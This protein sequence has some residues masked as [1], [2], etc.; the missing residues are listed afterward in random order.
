DRIR[1][2]LVAVFSAEADRRPSAGLVVD[3]VDGARAIARQAVDV[4]LELAARSHLEQEMTLEADGFERIG[5]KAR[6][7][8][9]G[10][11]LRT[12]AAVLL[13]VAALLD[14]LERAADLRARAVETCAVEL[15]CLFDSRSPAGVALAEHPFHGS[16]HLLAHERLDRLERFA[17][18]VDVAITIAPRTLLERR[19]AR[20]AERLE[21]G[22]RRSMG[23]FVRPLQCKRVHGFGDAPDVLRTDRGLRNG[24]RGQ[25]RS[26][27]ATKRYATH[28]VIAGRPAIFSAASR[29]PAPTST[30][31]DL[32]SP[33]SATGLPTAIAGASSGSPKIA[34]SDSVALPSIRSSIDGRH[35]SAAQVSAIAAR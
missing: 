24:Q 26:R 23:R 19:H 14:H 20:K 12:G 8:E 33:D 30:S 13:D 21:V 9:I 27:A 4:S 32:S 35:A 11:H 3:D 29:L 10:H 16:V 31:A 25:L 28:A 34:D 5:G 2:E 17:N 22:H 7:V 6:A 15:D 1:L 18:A